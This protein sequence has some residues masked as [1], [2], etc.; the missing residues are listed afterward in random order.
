MIGLGQRVESDLSV[1]LPPSIHSAQTTSLIGQKQMD[2]EIV[3]EA[4]QRTEV[5]L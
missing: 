3:P 2:E 1:S 4:E 5:D